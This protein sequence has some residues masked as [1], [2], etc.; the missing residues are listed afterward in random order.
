MDN[1]MPNDTMIDELAK[2]ISAFPGAANRTRCFTHIL[3]LTAKRS[4]DN[5]MFQS[6]RL[7]RFLLRPSINCDC[8]PRGS[9]WKNR[10]CW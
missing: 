1:A 2:L 5:L 9:R 3:N 7:M 6:C 8:W 10:R 4:C